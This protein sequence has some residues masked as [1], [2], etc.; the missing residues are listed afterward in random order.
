MT[1]RDFRAQDFEGLVD[2]YRQGFPEGHNRYALSRL[3]RFQQDTI[4]VAE[5]GTE[6]V[7]VI[8]GI[9]SHREAW[10]TGLS[11]LPQLKLRMTRVSMHLMHSLGKRF[12]E[13]GFTQAFATTSRR[14]VNTLAKRVNS[15]LLSE[16]PNFYFDG[17]VRSLYLADLTTLDNLSR[18]KEQRN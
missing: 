4:L 6:I 3:V 14:S 2:C 1:V 17:E 7:G 16:E 10:L 9:S 13:V 5:E 18:L 12:V 11:V 15:T 8:I